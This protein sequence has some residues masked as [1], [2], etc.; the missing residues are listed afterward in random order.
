MSTKIKQYLNIQSWDKIKTIASVN[1]KTWELIVLSALALIT[2]IFLKHPQILVGVII[3]AILIKGALSLKKYQL[4]P[5]IILPSVGVVLG[6][7]L[8]SG[9]TKFVFY[10][11]PFIWFGNTILI[12][13]FKKRTNKKYIS[14]LLLASFSKMTFLFLSA[15]I[16]YSLNIIPKPLLMAM[17]YMQFITAILGGILVLMELKIE[18]WVRKN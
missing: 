6:G 4:I 2:P 14:T 7:V 11:M 1:T 3:N 13:L 10:I 15:L 17:G 8:F 16:L 5:L 9:L 18:K 12:Y